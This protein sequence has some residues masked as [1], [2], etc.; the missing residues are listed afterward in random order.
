MTRRSRAREVALQL[1][2]QA[3]QNPVPVPA[4]A[5]EQFAR[6]RVR[7]DDLV[8]FTLEL[9]N[10]V[11]AHRE[12]IDAAVTATAENWRLHR[13][14]PADRNVLR[15]GVFE[16]LHDPAP[17]PA[18]AVINEAIELARRFG[19]ADSPAF[20][21][22]ILDKISRSRTAD[23]GAQTDEASAPP[24]DAPAGPS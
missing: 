19:T 15:L 17:A 2:F 13:M 18:A 12:A 11:R 7:D 6:D 22:G 1:L 16:L 10:G 5:V 4:A 9:Y 8:D 23:R 20:V 3:D 21:N 24:P 14:L